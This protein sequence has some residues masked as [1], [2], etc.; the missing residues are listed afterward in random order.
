MDW[1]VPEIYHGYHSKMAPPKIAD[2][3]I[4]ALFDQL[5]RL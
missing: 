2:L 5:K 3:S 1:F 4:V